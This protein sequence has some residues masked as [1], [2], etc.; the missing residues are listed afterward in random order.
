MDDD[1]DVVV[2]IR[3]PGTSVTYELAAMLS[4]IVLQLRA[5]VVLLQAIVYL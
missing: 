3:R 2:I 1:S 5:P 4:S